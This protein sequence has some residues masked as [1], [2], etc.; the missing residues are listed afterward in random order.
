MYQLTLVN[1]W[2]DTTLGD[3]D[4]T[5]KFVQFLIV[6]DGKLKVTRDDTG[7][8]VV[9]SGIARQFENFR[10]KVFEDGSEVNGSTCRV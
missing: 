3:G 6:T 4:M 7:L 1:V 9:T 10:S 5:Q 2:K 8:L